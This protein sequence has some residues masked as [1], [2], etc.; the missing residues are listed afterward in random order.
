MKPEYHK[1][2][3]LLVLLSVL[4]NYLYA[5]IDICLTFTGKPP[6]MT[7]KQSYILRH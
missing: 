2:Y 6:I 5:E 4:H 1:E 7:L 3:E